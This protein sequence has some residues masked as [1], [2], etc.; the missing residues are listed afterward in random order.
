MEYIIVICLIII[1]IQLSQVIRNVRNDYFGVAI[2]NNNIRVLLNGI[3]YL[4]SKEDREKYWQM[5]REITKESK[6]YEVEIR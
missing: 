1:I 6:K 2:L 4:L 5:E 3:P